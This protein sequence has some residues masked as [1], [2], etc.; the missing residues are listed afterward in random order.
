MDAV[1]R[2]LFLKAM[3]GA[4]MMSALPGTP[5]GIP[6]GGNQNVIHE[7]AAAE[8][9]AEAKPK[10]SIRFSV[11]GMSHDHIYGMV[12]ALLRGGGVHL[13]QNTLS[14]PNRVLS[15]GSFS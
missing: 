2:R 7:V 14:R 10:Y 8:Q 15:S 5:F 1:N 9:G 3:S 11:C 6:P 12:G 13:E 4:G